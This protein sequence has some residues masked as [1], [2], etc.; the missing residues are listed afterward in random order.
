MESGN[1]SFAAANPTST[2]GLEIKQNGNVN[3]EGLQVLAQPQQPHINHGHP[4]FHFETKDTVASVASTGGNGAVCVQPVNLSSSGNGPQRPTVKN[5]FVDPSQ[6][7]SSPVDMKGK[8]LSSVWL[9]LLLGL[10]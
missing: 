7:H 1:G 8:P 9:Y 10:Y 4:P 6:R 2:P 5:P 3:S